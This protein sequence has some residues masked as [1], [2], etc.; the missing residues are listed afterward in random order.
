MCITVAKAQ[1]EGTEE[2]GETGG[3]GEP[4]QVRIN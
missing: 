3:G 2:G 4:D 1:E